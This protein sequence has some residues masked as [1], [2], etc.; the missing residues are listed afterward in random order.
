MLI[1]QNLVIS[2]AITLPPAGPLLIKSVGEFV[3][4]L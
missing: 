4:P 3:I 2:G 1:G